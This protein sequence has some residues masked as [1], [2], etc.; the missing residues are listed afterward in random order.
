M[1]TFY[2]HPDKLIK[3]SIPNFIFEVFDINKP[4]SKSDLNIL[5][6]IYKMLEKSVA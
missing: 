2:N 1:D 5:T 6:E 4:F 3:E